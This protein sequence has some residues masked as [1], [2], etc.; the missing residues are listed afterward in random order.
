MFFPKAFP[1]AVV[2]LSSVWVQTNLAQAAVVDNA[3]ARDLGNVA[4]SPVLIVSGRA[5]ADDEV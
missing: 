1:L 2:F 4:V 3:V 5:L